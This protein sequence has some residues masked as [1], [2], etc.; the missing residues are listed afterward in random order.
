[1]TAW[2]VLAVAF[3]AAFG[4]VVI[5]LWLGFCAAD[6]ALRDDQDDP[7]PVPEGWDAVRRVDQERRHG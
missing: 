5:W 4:P 2:E 3:A 6:R 1:M 7:S